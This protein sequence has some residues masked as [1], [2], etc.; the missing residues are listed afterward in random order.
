MLI[1]CLLIFF[2]QKLTVP[3]YLFLREFYM[4]SQP[5]LGGNPPHPL[6]HPLG[7]QMSFRARKL[8]LPA[9]MQPADHMSIDVE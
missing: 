8:S 6:P 9:K 5:L 1:A 7:L 3:N 4:S 2:L